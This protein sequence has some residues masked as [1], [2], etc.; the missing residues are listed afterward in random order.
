MIP[1]LY[2]CVRHRLARVL[3]FFAT[4]R[5]MVVKIVRSYSDVVL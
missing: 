2:Y 3:V 1:S 5:Y 4:A